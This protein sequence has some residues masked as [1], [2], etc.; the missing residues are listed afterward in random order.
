M[1]CLP[2]P[3]ICEA[4][5][6]KYTASCQLP[7]TRWRVVLTLSSLWPRTNIE[8][9]PCSI[10]CL[11]ILMLLTTIIVSMAAPVWPGTFCPLHDINNWDLSTVIK[12]YMYVICHQIIVIVSN[13]Y[14]YH[15]KGNYNLNECVSIFFIAVPILHLFNVYL[16]FR[17]SKL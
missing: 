12:L 6:K 5:R 11:S 14:Q 15:R 9:K 2:Q 3:I 8:S 7:V 4:K 17:Q 1:T 13:L 10:L 16:R